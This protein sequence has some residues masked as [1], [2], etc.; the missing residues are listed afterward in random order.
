MVIPGAS[1]FTKVI[2][3]AASGNGGAGTWLELTFSSG[4]SGSPNGSLSCAERS[5]A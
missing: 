1:M 5:F 2:I 4:S 3:I